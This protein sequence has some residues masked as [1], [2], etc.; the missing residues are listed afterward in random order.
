MMVAPFEARASTT[1][2]DGYLT[3]YSLLLSM[4]AV[5]II[6][7]ASISL[8]ILCIASIIAMKFIGFYFV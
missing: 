1:V 4:F 6:T 8:P 5:G 7:L 2:I 3:L